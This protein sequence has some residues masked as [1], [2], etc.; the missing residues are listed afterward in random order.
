MISCLLMGGLGN[1]MFQIAAA[2]ALSLEV[3]DDFGINHEICYTPNQG[4]KSG[5]Y[6]NS[7]F[8]N[9]PT[10][11]KL[12][13]PNRLYEELNSKFTPLIKEKNQIIK[14]YFQSEK[15]FINHKE[16][17]KSLFLPSE[18]EIKEVKNELEEKKQNSSLVSIHIRRGDYLKFSHHHYVQT[19]DYY[20][21][22]MKY[23]PD[24]K[25]FIVSDDMN[26]AKENIKGENIIYSD[27]KD[28]IS[29]FYSMI[30]CDHNIISNSTFSWW[31]AYLGQKENKV[32]A[33]PKQW[34][35]HNAKIDISDLIPDKWIII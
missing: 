22:A 12:E 33:A 5:K 2:K 14:G 16:I 27:F 17:I 35:Q 15:Y 25:F 6:I 29:D 21:S 13:F 8:K 3:G 1:Q 18:N 31:A 10:I 26:W 24:S 4:N 23:F 34:Y 11:S 32:I 20:N 19:I 7:F 9:V 30:C 28:E